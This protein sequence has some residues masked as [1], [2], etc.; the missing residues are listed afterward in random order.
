MKTFRQD[1]HLVLGGLAEGLR[2]RAAQSAGSTL[3][4]CICKAFN[5]FAVPRDKA[6]NVEAALQ[7]KSTKA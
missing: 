6:A 3:T 5:R 4:V 1:G 2:Q 7:T